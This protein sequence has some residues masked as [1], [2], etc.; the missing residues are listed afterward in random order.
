MTEYLIAEPTATTLKKYGLTV[1]TWFEHLDRQGGSCGVC[2]EVPNPSKRDGKRRLVI[3]HEHV[4]GWKNMP[5]E[6]RA[7][8]VRGLTCFRCNTQYLGRGISVQRAE[9]LVEYLRAY[10]ERRPA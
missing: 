1:A 5:D 6:R 3:E 7:L 10:A 9:Y 4:R 2:R 8:Y